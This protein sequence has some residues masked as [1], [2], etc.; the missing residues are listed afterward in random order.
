M[1]CF[2]FKLF[3]CSYHENAD[4]SKYMESFSKVFTLG[5][6]V[7]FPEWGHS[8]LRAYF[9]LQFSAINFGKN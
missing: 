9:L 3:H 2:W 5:Y 6:Y 8:F 1:S 7:K 4:V